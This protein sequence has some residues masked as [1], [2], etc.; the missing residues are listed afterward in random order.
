MD[1]RSRRLRGNLSCRRSSPFL[2]QERGE[3]FDD[4]RHLAAR[5]EP[6]QGEHKILPNKAY[7]RLF[8]DARIYL[9]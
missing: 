6:L 3:P 8:G 1:T 4:T 9:H 7:Y 2:G 5:Y